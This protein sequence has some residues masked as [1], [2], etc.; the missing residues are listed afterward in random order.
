MQHV[1]LQEGEIDKQ[2]H[3]QQQQHHVAS[4]YSPF[5][6]NVHFNQPFLH[7]NSAIK[8]LQAASASTANG[9]VNNTSNVSN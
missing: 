9:V 4:N 7:E 6:A 3:Q 8:P 5:L 1:I 2:Q